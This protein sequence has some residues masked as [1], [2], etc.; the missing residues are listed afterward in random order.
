MASEKHNYLSAIDIFRDLSPAE[1]SEIERTT[2]MAACHTGRVFFAPDESGEALFLLKKGKVQ[3]YR[4][5]PEGKKLVIATLG[6]GAVFG[7]MALVG[8]GMHDAFAEALEEGLICVMSR[9]DVERII[10]WK[11]VVALRFIEAM[12]RRLKEAETRLEEIAFKN[13]PA[14]LATVLLRLAD[15]KGSGNLVE[16]YTHQDLAEMLG[17]YRE[18]AT[19]TLNS[20]KNQG[21]IEVG[22]KRVV[23][24]NRQGLEAAAER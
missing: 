1:V 7:E 23:V 5:S 12:G 10:R 2:T 19:Q 20:F 4:L 24:L 11:P 9:E 13:I 21:L 15:E 16:G 14:R 6:P 8:Q 22:R 18:T 3:L 17:T